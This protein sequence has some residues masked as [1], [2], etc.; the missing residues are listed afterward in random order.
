MVEDRN[1]VG[2]TLQK[3]R[4]LISVDRELHR[5]AARRLVDDIDTVQI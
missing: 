4:E 1:V 2:D 3:I 5:Y